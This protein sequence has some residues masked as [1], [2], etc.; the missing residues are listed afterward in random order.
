MPMKGAEMSKEELA[1]EKELDFILEHM[2][3][4]LAI[5]TTYKLDLVKVVPGKRGFIRVDIW[6]ESE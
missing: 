5:H 2:R 1:Q 4:L 3:E 6:D